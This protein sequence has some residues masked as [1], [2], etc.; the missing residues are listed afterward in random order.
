ME[1]RPSSSGCTHTSIPPQ[2][3]E[4]WPQRSV[5]EKQIEKIIFPVDNH[6][7]LPG[8]K[9]KAGPQLKKKRL[10]AR[11][12]DVL[13]ITFA[14][15]ALQFHDVRPTQLCS[16][17]RH[18]FRHGV[19]RC[20]FGSCGIEIMSLQ[21]TTLETC[22]TISDLVSFSSSLDFIV[23]RFRLVSCFSLGFEDVYIIPQQNILPLI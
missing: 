19:L 9:C 15:K 5:V 22:G 21:S 23:Y 20:F 13:K 8:K 12:K 10:N 17:S 16:D 2:T 1:M 7:L 4:V 14:V 18:N 11:N 3:G 6:V